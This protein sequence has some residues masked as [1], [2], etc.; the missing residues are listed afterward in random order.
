MCCKHCK[1]NVSTNLCQRNRQKMCTE[2]EITEEFLEW[3][4]E[5]YK[6]EIK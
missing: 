5:Q 1:Y 6:K 4:K 3:L 2:Y